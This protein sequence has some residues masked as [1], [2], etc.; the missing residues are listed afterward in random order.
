[1][2]MFHV[3]DIK[4]NRKSMI[5]MIFRGEELIIKPV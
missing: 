5:T 3:D 4:R 2:Q 1:M